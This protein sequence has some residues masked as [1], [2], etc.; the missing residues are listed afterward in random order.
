MTTPKARMAVGVVAIMCGCGT[1]SPGPTAPGDTPSPGVG[2]HGPT[3]GLVPGSSA[4]AA[5]CTAVKGDFDA[6]EWQAL[7]DSLAPGRV[8]SD[9][10]FAIP[11]VLRAQVYDTSSWVTVGQSARISVSNNDSVMSFGGTGY[12]ADSS[13]KVTETADYR[14]ARSLF[15]ALVRATEVTKS[16]PTLAAGTEVTVTRTSQNGKLACVLYRQGVGTQFPRE[17]AYCEFH[18]L[19]GA[20]LTHDCL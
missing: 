1:E 20:S 2:T 10:S 8:T 14:A 13:G 4:A 18:A 12:P 11:G 17:D 5:S 15:D 16:Q 9:V 19:A 3:S 7:T 6:G